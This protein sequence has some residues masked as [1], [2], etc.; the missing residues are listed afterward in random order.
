LHL[1]G[2]FHSDNGFEYIRKE[3]DKGTAHN[4]SPWITVFCAWGSVTLLSHLRKQPQ[5][6]GG[7]PLLSTMRK[8]VQIFGDFPEPVSHPWLKDCLAIFS[9]LICPAFSGHCEGEKL[10]CSNLRAIQLTGA[11]AIELRMQIQYMIAKYKDAKFQ[12]YYSQQRPLWHMQEP[13]GRGPDFAGGN[14]RAD[15][16]DAAITEDFHL[17]I[18]SFLDKLQ[19]LCE[20]TTRRAVIEFLKENMKRL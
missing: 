7:L 3:L 11:E 19:V 5:A 20:C 4:L 12:E 1:T 6:I 15:E 16:I 13:G 17:V 14:E 8:V 18:G 9:A 10:S 2:Q